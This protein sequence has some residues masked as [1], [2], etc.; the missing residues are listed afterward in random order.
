M[1]PIRCLVLLLGAIAV[2]AMSG[3]GGDNGASSAANGDKKFEVQA[4]TTMTTGSLSKAQFIVHANALCR[5]GWPRVRENYKEYTGFQD[6]KGSQ[7]ERFAETVRLS[8]LASIDFHIFDN[9]HFLG[10]P[11]GEAADVEEIIGPLQEAVERGQRLQPIYSPAELWPL[12]AVFNRRARAYGST[13]VSSTRPTQG[14]DDNG[15]ESLSGAGRIVTFHPVTK[16]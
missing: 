3:C 7:K 10:A 15:A 12:F 13:T 2:P 14:F 9:I 16:R 11:E 8:L 6:R 5:K 1:T 4:D